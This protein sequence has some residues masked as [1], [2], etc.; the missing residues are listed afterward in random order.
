L[1][2]TR[3]KEKSIWL[4]VT[5]FSL[6]DQVG[7]DIMH[8][9]LEGC[10]SYIMSFILKS[11]IRKLKLFSLKVLNDRIFAFD[12]GPEHNKPYIIFM[13]L[14]NV[15]K[16]KQSASE[17]LSFIRYF[18]LLISDFVP[19]GEPNWHLYLCMHRVLDIALSTSLEENSYLLLENV[20]GEMNEPY[21]KL[22]KNVLKPKFNFLTHYSSM[23]K[24]T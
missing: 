1:S 12:Y 22:S 14:I 16:M 5:D 17:M 20:V 18:G 8:D 7:V 24:K 11:Y 15:G 9:L 6:F 2:A 23:I 13:D 4:N 21:L 3:L 10:A 19:V